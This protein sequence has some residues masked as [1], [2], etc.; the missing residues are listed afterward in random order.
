[1]ITA[2][3]LEATDTIDENDWCRPLSIVSMSGGHSD[4]YSFKNMYSG[5][6]ENNAEWVRVKDVIGRPWFGS[7]VKAY[8]RGVQA[9]YEFVR[10]DVP[11]SHRLKMK[12][13]NRLYSNKK[14]HITEYNDDIPF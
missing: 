4:S 9:R 13:Y 10:G 11:S 8:C 3:F 5:T 2:Q 7:T 6:P 1:M 12:G 14:L